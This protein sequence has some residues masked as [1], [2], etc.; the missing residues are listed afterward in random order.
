MLITKSQG[1]TFVHMLLVLTKVYT[2]VTKAQVNTCI[3]VLYRCIER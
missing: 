3:H 2:G 1:N